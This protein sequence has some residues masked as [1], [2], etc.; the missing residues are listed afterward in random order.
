MNDM[1]F[2]IV[3]L[4]AALPPTGPGFLSSFFAIISAA[5]GGIVWS[6]VKFINKAIKKN[7]DDKK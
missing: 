6:A 5:V 7:K 1:D 4:D 3:F 2:S